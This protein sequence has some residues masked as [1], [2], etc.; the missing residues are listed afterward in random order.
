MVNCVS[1]DLIYLNRNFTPLDISTGNEINVMPFHK[2]I[3]LVIAITVSKTVSA[4]AFKRQLNND[5]LRKTL[6]HCDFLIF[7]YN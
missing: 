7:F 6:S 2:P 5:L 1:G 3:I 4:N